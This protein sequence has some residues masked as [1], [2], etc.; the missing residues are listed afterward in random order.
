MRSTINIYF[1]VLGNESRFLSSLLGMY[2]TW[3]VLFSVSLT[4]LSLD[5]SDSLSVNILDIC[6]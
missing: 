3:I 5:L 4:T 6:E 2:W 1:V